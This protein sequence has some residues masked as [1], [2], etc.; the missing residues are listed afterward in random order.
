MRNATKYG[1]QMLKYPGP[2]TF[3]GSCRTASPH[4]R[5]WTF[6]ASTVVGV[7]ND[8]PPYPYPR[9]YPTHDGG[10]GYG[11]THGLWWV[12]LCMGLAA[13]MNDFLYMVVARSYLKHNVIPPILKW[14]L[15]FTL[16]Y[17]VLSCDSPDIV[18]VDQIQQTPLPYTKNCPSSFR[19]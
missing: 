17:I 18:V 1:A 16:W 13:E 8:H 5:L 19:R 9:N 3:L 4:L 11:L 15:I 2:L 14:W 7:I 10:Y 12:G 6:P